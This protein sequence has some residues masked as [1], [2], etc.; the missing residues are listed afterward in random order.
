MKFTAA[1]ANSRM[2]RHAGA[3]ILSTLGSENVTMNNHHYGIWTDHFE[4]TKPLSSFYDIL[5]VN[6]D[7]KGNEFISTIESF[8][9]PI[10]GTQW[11]PEKNS[12]EW[13]KQADGSPYESID[14]SS[15]GQHA[16]QYMSDFFVDQSRKSLHSFA[17]FEEEDA[18]LMSNYQPTRT[19]TDFTQ[20]YFLHF[21]KEIIFKSL[22][23][24]DTECD[25]VC[26]CVCVDSERKTERERE[27]EETERVSDVV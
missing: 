22:F 9:F 26:V 27:R 1:A 18:L 5:S 23:K 16:M 20:T 24:Y 21:W 12:F 25:C 13:N 6:Q 14:H 7:R 19:Y 8:K 15:S 2:F 17:D 11:H 4:N 10:Y 3:D